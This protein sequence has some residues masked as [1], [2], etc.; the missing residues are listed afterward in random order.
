MKFRPPTEQIKISTIYSVFPI[1]LYYKTSNNCQDISC[2][3]LGK[4]VDSVILFFKVT[5]NASFKY[6]K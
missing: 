3:S 4:L 1:L 6:V 2:G 5:L